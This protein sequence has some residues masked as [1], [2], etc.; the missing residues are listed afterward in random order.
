MQTHL[1]FMFNREKLYHSRFKLDL[2]V[3]F[4]YHF[5]HIIIKPLV[6]FLILDEKISVITYRLRTVCI[7]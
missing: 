7:F 6:V 3:I 1:V 5:L 2:N 4:I